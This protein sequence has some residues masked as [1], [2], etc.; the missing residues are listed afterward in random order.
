LGFVVVVVCLRN[1]FE[2]MK[3]NDRY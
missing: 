1:T 2:K 3:P